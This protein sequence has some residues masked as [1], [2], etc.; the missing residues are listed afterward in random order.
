[1]IVN[2]W[3]GGK[4]ISTELALAATAGIIAL[5]VLISVLKTRAVP[6]AQ[7]KREA[8]RWWVPGSPAKAGA[9]TGPETGPDAGDDAAAD[10]AAVADAAA[11]GEAEDA[12][13]P[14][15]GDAE[16]PPKG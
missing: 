12:T 10:T 2:A 13:T 14:R 8:A 5:S 7:E 3:F 4:V 9:E 1:M 16:G 15:P 11:V 6:G